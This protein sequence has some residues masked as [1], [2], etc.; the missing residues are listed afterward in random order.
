MKKSILKVLA[1]MLV[2]V[3]AITTVVIPFSWDYHKIC[4]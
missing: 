4:H 3:M 2:L 1:S